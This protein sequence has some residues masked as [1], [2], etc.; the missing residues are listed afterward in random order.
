MDVRSSYHK[1]DKMITLKG[2]G[3]EA[4]TYGVG[5]MALGPDGRTLVVTL[6]NARNNYGFGIRGPGGN[7]IVLDLD[8]LNLTTGKINPPVKATTGGDTTVKF[9]QTVTATWDKD[10]FLVASP[11]DVNRGLGALTLTRDDSGKVTS[12]ALVSIE[13]PQTFNNVKIDRLNIQRAQS[14]VLVKQGGIEYAIVSDDNHPFEDAYVQAMFEAP[15]FVS[16]GGPPIPFGGSA[17]AKKVAVSGKLGIVQDPFGKL[18]APKYLGATLPLDGYGIINLSLSEDGKVLI[19]QLSGGYSANYED[20][21]QKPHQNHAW[22]VPELIAAALANPQPLS[23]HIKLA[24]EAEQLIPIATSTNGYTAPPAGTAFDA[25]QVMVTAIGNMG[26]VIK[27]D[28]K[29]LAARKMLNIDLLKPETALTT[30]SS[31]RS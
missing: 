21:Q 6:P 16:L 9:P 25:A 18:G 19:G 22:S 30:L 1:T 29:D 3:I 23:K 8:S 7:V 11:D 28:L 14:A 31:T 10:R 5:G 17:S 26:D 13:M 2:T 27:V 15:M 20:S 12:A 4:T 24:A